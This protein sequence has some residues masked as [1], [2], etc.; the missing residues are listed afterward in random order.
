MTS[1]QRKT[2]IH[3]QRQL[4][5]ASVSAPWRKGKT[6]P[7][8]TPIM[9]MPEALAVY[10]FSPTVASVKI[11]PHMTEWNNPTETSTHRL[12]V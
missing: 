3:D 11:Q 8:N 7:P 2:S 12:W 4:P 5:S 10:F 6:A 9:K 1:S